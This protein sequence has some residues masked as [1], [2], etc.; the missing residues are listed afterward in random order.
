MSKDVG[1]A[2]E[3]LHSSVDLGANITTV[4][5]TPA[6][7]AGAVVTSVLS[8]HICLVTDGTDRIDA[9]VASTAQGSVTAGGQTVPIRVA[10]IVVDPDDAATG[11]LSVRYKKDNEGEAGDGA[12]LP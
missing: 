12:G 1:T 11:T 2:P 7:Y 3:W 4:I 9:L 8:A 10:K 5:A 6:V